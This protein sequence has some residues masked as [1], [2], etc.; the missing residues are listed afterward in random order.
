MTPSSHGGAE[1][2]AH[3]IRVLETAADLP[4]NDDATRAQIRAL[5]DQVK[6]HTK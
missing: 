3:A 5:L 1:W 6:T 4:G 2:F